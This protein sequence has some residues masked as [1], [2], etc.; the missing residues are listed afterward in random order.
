MFSIF[1]F[2]KPLIHITLIIRMAKRDVSSRYRGSI[3]GLLWS[4]ITPILMLAIYTFVFSEIF[5]VRWGGLDYGPGE[6]AL[7]LFSG[8]IVFNFFSENIN[9]SPNLI[10]ENTS[11]VKKVVFPLEILPVTA[12][13]SALFSAMTST[14]VLLI[15]LL[16]IGKLPGWPIFCLPLIWIPFVFL[17]WGFS[18]FLSGLGVYLRDLRHIVATG[19]TIL[20]FLS[21]IF[22]PVS[23]LPESM[24]RIIYL[25]PLTFFIEQNRAIFIENRPP[26]TIPLI[27]AA[28][29]ACFSAAIGYRL[30]EK[31]KKGFADVI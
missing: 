18:W 8:L 11:F 27:V 2:L 10:L 17:T 4:V 1:P 5:K 7:R 31:M 28:A 22:Y 3:L 12:T 20:L 14:G 21:P 29:G 15:G 9:R 23:A 30:F 26:E 24:R 19:V 6:F 16:L 25:N 13:L